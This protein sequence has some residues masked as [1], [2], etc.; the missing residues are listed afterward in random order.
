MTG[1]AQVLIRA[2]DSDNKALAAPVRIGVMA[3][4]AADLPVEKLQPFVEVV[5]LHK[6]AVPP[7]S[8]VIVDPDGVR[9]PD[10]IALMPVDAAA[11]LL[12]VHVMFVR[13][14]AAYA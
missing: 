11:Q 10:A 12:L 3:G 1:Q 4:A 9:K 14:V 2:L 6:L 7:G 13:P 8:I 5:C